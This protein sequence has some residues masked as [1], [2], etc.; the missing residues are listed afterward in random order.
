M[1]YQDDLLRIDKLCEFSASG[2]GV[3]VVHALINV[4]TVAYSTGK[5]DIIAA[6]HLAL[7]PPKEES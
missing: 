6:A 1:S 3:S 4:L 7:Y 5:E 2:D